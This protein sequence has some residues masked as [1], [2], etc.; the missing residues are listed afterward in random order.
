MKGLVLVASLVVAQTPLHAQQPTITSQPA[1]RAVWIG[2]NVLFTVA[3]TGTGPFTYQWQLNGT[4]LPNGT[5]ST[6]AGN[7]TNAFSGDGGPAINASL[8]QPQGVT[9]D[10]FGNVFIADQNNQRIR[11]A[12]ADGIITTVAGNGMSAFSGDGGT[13]TNASLANPEGITLDQSGNVF[14][15]DLSNNRIRRVNTNGVI[16][17]VAGNASYG[18]NGDGGAATQTSLWQPFGVAVDPS[19]NV[20][21]G[22]TA[23][24]RVRKVDTNGIITTVAGN[25]TRAYSGDGGPA[26]NAG[27]NLP[28]G[29]A[30]DAAGNLFIADQDNQRIRK[31]DTNGF[32]TTVAGNGTNAYSGDGG[33]ATNASLNFPGGVT[34]DAVG[35]LFIADTD[36]NRIR[37]VNTNGIITTVAGNSMYGYS[38]DGGVPT[39]ASLFGPLGVAVDASGNLFIGD[40]FNARVRKVTEMQGPTL[41]LNNTTPGNAGS[42]RVVVTG[43]GGSV[44]SSVASL[45]IITSPVIYGT[46]ALFHGGVTLFGVSQP[47]ASNVVVC[48]TNFSRA[49]FWQPLA[50]NIAGPDGDW[51]YTDTNAAAFQARFY[52][53]LTPGPP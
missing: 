51:Q 35:N 52:R 13:A 43:S 47:G 49:V 16:S 8:Y 24:N 7:G 34:A 48:A 33:A 17:T 28:A 1:P 4:N 21:I 42:Y 36:N 2:C 12:S 10:R 50:T 53:S 32:I 20:F 45:T 30:L 41:T 18:Y 46:V 9:V 23:D 3:A 25:G 44:T 39:N 38:G 29:V 6:V 15:A 19:G 14:I 26:T 40:T 22:D 37:R 31:I 11:K 5:I 27:L